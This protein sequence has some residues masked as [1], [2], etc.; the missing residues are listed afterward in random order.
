MEI[1][2]VDGQKVLSASFMTIY[3]FRKKRG[4]KKEEEH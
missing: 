2:N 4:R 1:K 3:G